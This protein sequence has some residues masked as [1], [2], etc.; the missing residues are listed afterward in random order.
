MV[1]RMD[2]DGSNLEVLGHNFRN[3]YEVAIDSYGTLW[4]SDNDDDGN[5]AVRINYVMEFGNYGFRDE[6]TGANWRERRTGWHDEIPLRH[7]HLRDPGVVPNLLQTGAGSPT[8]IVI[9]EADLLPTVFQGEMIHA[10]AGPNVV[11]SYPV[12]RSGAGYTAEIVDILKGVTDQWFRPSDVAIAPDGSLIIA[13]WYDP[14]VGG[15]HVGDL[16]R[17]RL[18][19]VA[20]PGTD[21]VVPELDLGSIE[22]AV[23]AL[24][25]PN[26]ATRY[27]AWQMLHG[28]GLEAEEALRNV[29]EN[30]T[31]PRYRARA[32]WLLGK[33]PG[34]AERYVEEALRDENEDIRITGIRLAR[35][36]VSELMPI[37]QVLSSDPSP[38]IRREVAIALR[39]RSGPAAAEL[40]ADLA[41]RHDGADRWYLE[42]LGIAA[43]GK[44][45]SFFSAW[46]QRNQED[47]DTP[48]GRD[49][50]WRARTNDAM[51]MLVSTILDAATPEQERLR[52]FRAF[53]FHR[54]EGAKALL[55]PTL[56]AHEGDNRLQVT[57]LA[58]KH[59]AND[60]ALQ[61][62]MVQEALNWAVQA[63]RGTRLHLDLVERFDIDSEGDALFDLALSNGEEEL[64]KDALSLLLSIEGTERLKGAILTDQ[65][66]GSEVLI[67]LLVDSGSSAGRQ[68]LEELFLDDTVDMNLR[69]VAFNA[70]GTG[71]QGENGILSL[72]EAGTFPEVFNAPA[73]SIL[74]SSSDSRRRLRAEAFFDPPADISGEPLPAIEDLVRREGDTSLG[75]TIYTAQCGICHV[76]NG[77]GIDFGPALTNIGAKLPREALYQSILFPSGGISFGYEGVEVIMQDG[78]MAAGYVLS[79]TDSELSVRLAGGVTQA[80]DKA[81]IAELREMDQSLMPELG[82]AMGADDLVNLVA[83]LETLK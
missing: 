21:Y 75:Q 27:L 74:F 40:W 52:Y 58:L 80:F 46:L 79:E 66:G 48:A 13:D 2:E 69:T 35:Q 29:F 43:E 6:M 11:R 68:V 47:W 25:S 5:E 67:P 18:F 1:F 83:Y 59:L 37:L 44:W 7:W 31:N 26:M 24:K 34:R 36:E 19:R 81:G 42:A 61:Q 56:L 51:P 60:E 39:Y 76:V 70:Y 77:E 10:D 3:N 30:D 62:P 55:L 45:D 23:E 73:A 4:Q 57:S 15:H 65:H 82:P 49:I 54:D 38:Q 12:A 28:A 78:N 8:G 50:V 71:W 16:S 14:G 72:L 17:G 22:G 9:Y 32:L 53:D 64:G 20:P 33:I 41:T 63:A